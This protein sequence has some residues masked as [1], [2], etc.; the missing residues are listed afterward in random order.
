M[1]CLLFPFIIFFMASSESLNIDDFWL[2]VCPIEG[3]D[4]LIEATMDL[5]RAHVRLIL[6]GDLTMEESK[7]VLLSAFSL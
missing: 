6:L 2:R 4:K 1:F 3:D 5:M 7:L